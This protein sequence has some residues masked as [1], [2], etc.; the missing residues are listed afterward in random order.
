[1]NIT[2]YGHSCFLVEV[3][4]KRVLFDP[5]I[6]PN[7]LA[8]TIKANA[9][10]TDFIL[11]SH[12]HDDHLLDAVKIAKNNR[13]RVIANY[14]VAEWMKKKGVAHVHGVNPGG[15]VTLDFGRVKSVPA[16]HS[17][18]FPNGDYAGAASGF[19]VESAEG[20]FYYSG[21]TALTLDMKLIAETTRLDFA[22]LCIGG[23]FT[24]DVED[25]ILA[26]D[27]VGCDDVMGVHYDT[28]PEIKINHEH[29]QKKFKARGKKLR[30][31]KI[32]ETIT[33]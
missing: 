8:K 4:G 2:Y 1:M 19:V 26:A 12:G 33:L 25:A 30:L 32:G 31:L 24:M 29:A 28:F 23:N 11:I 5:F 18:S 16:I 15:A 21:D 7:P 3:A 14:E 6:S 22:I 10:E 13:A 20:N 9:I 17:S 27:F